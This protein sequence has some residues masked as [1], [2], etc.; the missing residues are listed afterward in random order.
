MVVSGLRSSDAKSAHCRQWRE[1][2]CSALR[3]KNRGKLQEVV[4][5]RWLKG[6][7]PRYATQTQYAAPLK[8][9][10]KRPVRWIGERVEKARFR[11]SR[12]SNRVKHRKPAET[13]DGAEH[14]SIAKR[15]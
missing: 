15:E 12:G 13:V 6:R 3:F 11:P 5:R 8:R 9:H 14:P 1:R 7:W 10:V 4:H 2:T